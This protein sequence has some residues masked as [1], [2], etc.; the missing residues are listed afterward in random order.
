MSAERLSMRRIREVLRLKFEGRS[1][2]EIARSVQISRPTVADYLRR[3][4]V[5]G[6]SWPL[7]E[8][9]DVWTRLKEL[10]GLVEPHL[11]FAQ[12]VGQGFALKGVDMV[13]GF[14]AET[15]LGHVV[16][17]V[18]L[19][20]TPLAAPAPRPPGLQRRVQRAGSMCLVAAH[21]T[22]CRRL[23]HRSCW[24][25]PAWSCGWGARLA[26]APGRHRSHSFEVVHSAPASRCRRVPW[27]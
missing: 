27:Q 26:S 1:V 10:D 21:L 16:D 14:E 2:R 3:A 20:G 23:F 13:G 4:K 24:W 7:P 25:S 12:G 9:L 18:A 8:E 6:V 17:G 5:G 15:G 11:V 22:R 19:L